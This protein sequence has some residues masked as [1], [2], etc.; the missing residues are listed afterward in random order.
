MTTSTIDSKIW[1]IAWPAIVAN[2]SIPLLGL[3]DATLLGHLDS[4][5]HLAAVAVGGAVISFLYW[6][7]S[8]LR[9]GTTGE[10][11]RAWGRGDE[12]LALLILGRAVVMA[13]GLAVLLG[14]LHNPLLQIGL[15]LMNPAPGIHDLARAYAELRLYS[16]P[17]VLST[18]A[19]VG[20][21]IGHQNTRWPMAIVIVTNLVNI[22]LDAWFILGLGMASHLDLR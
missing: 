13:L 20:W 21:F 22:A 19:A 16:A 17:A 4:P 1:S 7:F 10:V 15:A 8:F 5:R 3:A 18:Y 9:M 2:I 6:G 14:L 12:A 11:A